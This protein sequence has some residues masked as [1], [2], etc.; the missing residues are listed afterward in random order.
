MKG[1]IN[2][3]KTKWFNKILIEG[4]C[5]LK[6][7]WIIYVLFLMFSTTITIG[8]DNRT[9]IDIK[10]GF[11]SPA[12]NFDNYY[13]SGIGFNV[14]VL[15]PFYDN[16]QFSLNTGYYNWSFDNAAYNLRNSNELYTEFNFDAPMIM[17][18]ITIGIKYYATDL[19]VR[20]Y[21]SAEFGFFYYSQ[22]ASGTYTWTH[23][24]GTPGETYTLA[25]LND[26]GF[27]P[28][29]NAGAGVVAPLTKNWDLDFHIKMNAHLNAQSVSGSNN[30][31]AVEGSSSTLYFISLTGG[32]NYYFETK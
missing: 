21:F 29:L 31:G 6:L 23:K 30:S 12:F 9:G 11:N 32:I 18:P 7:I 2:I 10:A 27:R 20:P 14:G 3:S 5:R 15:Y 4:C 22:E 19:K 28:M 25:P 26:S 24:P 8:Q 13:E 1:T 17:I 16:L